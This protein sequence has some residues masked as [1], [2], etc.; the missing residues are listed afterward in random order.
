MLEGSEMKNLLK[1]AGRA[2]LKAFVVTFLT[3]AGGLLAATNL[4]EFAAL[5]VAALSGTFW[6]IKLGQGYKGFP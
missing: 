3:F 1:E 6:L 5:A 2:A 4:K